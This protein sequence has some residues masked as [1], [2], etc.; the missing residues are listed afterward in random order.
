MNEEKIKENTAITAKK[1]RGVPFK[2]GY[3]QRRNLEGRPG[4]SKN[5]NTIFEEAIRKIVKEQKI[6]IKDPE[7]EMVAK[8]IVEAIRGNYLF[9]RDLMDRRY[10][11]PQQSFDIKTEV[12]SKIISIDE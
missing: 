11:K 5:F 9:F 3:D 1:V 8:A 2:E 10:G 4:G 7:V 6:Q 12:E